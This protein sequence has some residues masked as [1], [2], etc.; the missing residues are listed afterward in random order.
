[1]LPGL[2]AYS[3]FLRIWP[4]YFF[5]KIEIFI[6]IFQNLFIRNFKAGIFN[7][8]KLPM[9]FSTCCMSVIL[10]HLLALNIMTDNSKLAEKGLGIFNNN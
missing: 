8:T 2:I 4:T 5:F 9:T 1:M 10:C 7:E 3:V 6:F